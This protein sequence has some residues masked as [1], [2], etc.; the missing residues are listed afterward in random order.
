[1]SRLDRRGP[2]RGDERRAAILAALDA[3][4]KD[5]VTLDDINVAQLSERA[6]VTRSA[7]YFYFE[8]KS[9]AVMALLE[10]MYDDVALATDRLLDTSTE[11]TDRIRGV[12]A[13]LFDSVDQRPYAYRA[14]LE[15]RAAS[16]TVRD[17]WARGLAGFAEEIA[18]MI[19]EERAAGRAVG[20]ADADAL[21]A[22][23][24]DLNDRAVERYAVG[25]GP[26]R[27]R[28]IDA[29]TSIWV[30]TIYGTGEGR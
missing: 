17:D 16:A 13:S 22:V 8:N 26:D 29:L 3:L 19:T 14:L 21:A 15:A 2:N 23:L 12:I 6:G 4:L 5:G 11:P 18:T 9:M 28:H 27:E 1:M 24:L 20:G 10:Q 25:G 30:S 7:F